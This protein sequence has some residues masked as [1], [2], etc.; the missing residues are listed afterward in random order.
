S[1]I[2]TINMGADRK[3]FVVGADGQPVLRDIKVG[4]SNERMV[5]V[6]SG[7]SEGERVVE[8]PRPLLGENSEMRP[9]KPGREVGGP[10][11]WEKGGKGPDGKGAPD[12]KK[13]GFPGGGQPKGPGAGQ[14]GAANP[15]VS[16]LTPRELTPALDRQWLATP[17]LRPA[18]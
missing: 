14:K 3:V 1:V 17:V 10:G 15:G 9:G 18:P 11:G 8:N 7:L 2:G 4:M 5:E 16:L 13:G 6:T 12:G